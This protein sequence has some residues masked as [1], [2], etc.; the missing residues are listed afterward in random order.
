ME[1]G[2]NQRLQKWLENI[3]STEDEELDCAALGEV[4]EQIIA[5]ASRGEDIRVALPAVAVHLDHCPECGEMY[6]ELVLLSQ[7]K[8]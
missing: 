7:E 1:D 5:I 6:E 2:L 4:L 8:P 3:A